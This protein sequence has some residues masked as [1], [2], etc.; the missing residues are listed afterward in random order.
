M[1]ALVFTLAHLANPELS[2]GALWVAANYA[3]AGLYL[4]ILALKGRGLELPIGVHLATNL[5]VILIARP[6]ISA[7]QTPALFIQSEPELAFSLLGT[8]VL[9]AVHYF[10]IMRLVPPRPGAENGR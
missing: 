4:S 10:V 6:E 2:Y 3:L 1:P 5:F 8:A 9:F 7:I